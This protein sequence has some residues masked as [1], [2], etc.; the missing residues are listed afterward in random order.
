MLFIKEYENCYPLYFTKTVAYFLANFG[1]LLEHDVK[2]LSQQP[3][4]QSSL[5]M[6]SL[7]YKRYLKIQ[8]ASLEVLGL[9]NSRTYVAHYCTPESMIDRS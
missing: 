7:A 4:A 5:Y 9:A 8:L 1:R 3:V 2:T 6:V